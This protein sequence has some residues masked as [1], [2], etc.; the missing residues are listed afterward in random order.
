MNG[1]YAKLL[2][3]L[4]R[5]SARV[6]AVF[7]F[8]LLIPSEAAYASFP[9]HIKAGRISFQEGRVI[10]R[11]NVEIV[12]K[13]LQAVSEYLEVDR[14]AQTVSLEG[15]VV[16]SHDGQIIVGDIIEFNYDLEEITAIDGKLVL[17][18]E[19]TDAPLNVFG[20]V[21]VYRTGQITVYNSYITDCD[22]EYPHYYFTARELDLYFDERLVFRNVS[23]WEGGYR[24]LSLPYLV[25]PLKDENVL[26]F[27]RI[28]FSARDGFF[29]KTT[30]NYYRSPLSYGSV[31]LDYM[32]KKGIGTGVRH[33]YQ[34]GNSNSGDLYVYV[35]GSRPQ[36]TLTH[37]C[38]IGDW[39]DTSWTLAYQEYAA[40]SLLAQ[41]KWRS[42]VTTLGLAYVQ[43]P[44]VDSNTRVKGTVSHTQSIGEESPILV[45]AHAEYDLAHV[46]HSFG[47]S[48]KAGTVDW[49]L[50]TT[51][52]KPGVSR[53]TENQMP[54]L[55]LS[56]RE[57]QF[58][59]TKTPL[60]LQTEL[61]RYIVRPQYSEVYRQAYRMDC[62]PRAIVVPKVVSLD[63]SAYVQRIIYNGSMQRNIWGADAGLTGAFS[64]VV[65]P[66][67]SYSHRRVLGE[68]LLVRDKADDLSLLS[69]GLA[70]RTN[71]F[72]IGVG[73]SYDLL[74]KRLG[75]IQGN[76]SVKSS[77]D[78]YLEIA[79]AYSLSLQAFRS[80]TTKLHFE[81]TDTVKVNVGLRYNLQQ[82][83]YEALKASAD[84]RL[85]NSWR[86]ELTT[87]LDEVRG[88]F[89]RRD[90][91]LTRDLHCRELRFVYQ[92]TTGA[93]WVE[94]RIKVLPSEGLKF[95]FAEESVVFDIDVPSSGEE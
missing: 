12:Y 17:V 1:D 25:I 54:Q 90:L 44:L 64:D 69:G 5:L 53:I 82:S 9:A 46:D 48:G 7:L 81:P 24:I 30:Y 32:Q 83:R 86:V 29:V 63:T 39:L 40:L 18:L 57:L 74:G 52:K 16:V 38:A 42:G 45:K 34:I 27:P 20:D 22:M 88:E 70:Y 61:G 50:G 3:Y 62:R 41:G 79:S 4:I 26:Q 95:G 37:N 85:R 55:T 89:T 31:Y 87:E 65:I 73:S 15:S 93:M 33:Y 28:G 6:V 47:V 36:I 13:D 8:L 76:L 59:K 23:Y 77:E 58:G 49:E 43:K 66:S 94:Y 78:V 84:I 68:S 21:M 19:N 56:T 11:D 60:D 2:S 10:A 71:K 67:L 14:A 91:A 75:D 72:H 51:W 92:G 35:Q 80:V